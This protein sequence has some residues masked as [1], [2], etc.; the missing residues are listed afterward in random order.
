MSDLAPI[1][2][3]DFNMREGCILE[4]SIGPLL[5]QPLLS[6]I[7]S[8]DCLHSFLRS[9]E[10]MPESSSGG[11]GKICHK[12]ISYGYATDMWTRKE[13]SDKSKRQEASSTM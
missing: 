10:I 6:R 2:L 11:G 12:L 4:R 8:S 7:L 1:D 5:I 3:E 13:V 9:I